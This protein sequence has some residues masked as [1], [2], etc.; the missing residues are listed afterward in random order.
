MHINLWQFSDL[1]T[2][3]RDFPPSSHSQQTQTAIKKKCPGQANE[4]E[5]LLSPKDHLSLYISSFC[6]PILNPFLTSS[7]QYFKLTT[8]IQTYSHSISFNYLP[9]AFRALMTWCYKALWGPEE[10]QFYF[11][12]HEKQKAALSDPS[13]YKRASSHSLAFC[14]PLS[15]SFPSLSAANRSHTAAARLSPTDQGGCGRKVIWFAL[16][17]EERKTSQTYPERSFQILNDSLNESDQWL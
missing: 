2:Y 9:N 16:S 7:N 4:A 8:I 13:V 12:P 3:R 14:L 6:C 5:Q 1:V 15:F 11:S 17:C 10:I